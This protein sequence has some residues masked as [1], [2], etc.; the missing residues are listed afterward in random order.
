LVVADGFE[1]QDRTVTDRSQAAGQH[2]TRGTRAND[3]MIDGQV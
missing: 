2:A 3:E 1:H